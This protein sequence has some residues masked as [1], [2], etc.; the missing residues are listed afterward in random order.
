MKKHSE[1][2]PKFGQKLLAWICSSPEQEALLGD[3]AETYRCRIGAKG[4]TAAV[5]WY[6]LQIVRLLPGIFK[7]SF[8]WSIQM[9]R[10]YLKV[11]LRNIRQHKG[12]AF[13]NVA[14]LSIGMTCF[15]LILLFVKYELSFDSYHEKADQ[16]HRVVLERLHSGE[17]FF[18]APTM[19][20]LAPALNDNL[21]EI[22][23]AVR[24][25]QR[26]SDLVSS[27]NKFFYERLLY[28]D[29]ELFETFSFP[30]LKGDAAAALSE[31]FSIVITESIAEKYF[32]SQDP[33]DKTLKINNAQ[34]YK[35]TG[36]LAEIPS[37]S[38]F[39][40]HLM[41]S[42]SSLNN[43]ERVKRGSWTS[44]RWRLDSVA[45]YAGIIWSVD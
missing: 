33:M 31:P 39:R 8:F 16:I 25:S 42:F 32:G 29:G 44:R 27:D 1:A 24:V 7:D 18:M 11:T 20:P 30:L 22:T 28:G 6:W 13:I 19:L 17:S 23:Q 26:R 4:K 40:F 41:A 35:I 14:G 21:P 3:F 36:I 5:V 15:I 12:Y 9:L 37:N 43:T 34:E 2:V 45:R 10:N 38:H